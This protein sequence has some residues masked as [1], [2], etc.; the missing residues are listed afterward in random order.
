VAVIK[1]LLLAAFLLAP[2]PVWAAITSAGALDGGGTSTV[3]GTTL[4]ITT[5]NNL[6]AGNIPV[7]SIAADNIGTTDST[8]TE[9]VSGTDSAGNTYTRLHSYR[10]GQAGAGLGASAALWFSTTGNALGSGGTIT[11]TFSSAI[12]AKAAACREY[13]VES[14]NTLQVAPSGTAEEAGDT[15]DPGALVL[16]LPSKE[17]LFIRVVA[18]ETDGT[19]LTVTTNY[20]QGASPTADPG[21][22]ADSMAL[23][24]EW[25]ITTAAGDTSN[26][27]TSAD[28]DSASI[29][30]ALEEC[31][32]GTD[33]TGDVIA[34]V[35]ASPV[36]F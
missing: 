15:T 12:T 11:F 18:M 28:L 30:V 13:A 35:P 21:L 17:Y 20:T 26:P 7:C 4:V 36:I 27:A 31:T 8:N 1:R 19:T 6:A 29:Y 24:H 3:S 33:C 25:R 23:R 22:T 10:N 2:S 9:I 16:T 32:P 34:V 5:T 14:G